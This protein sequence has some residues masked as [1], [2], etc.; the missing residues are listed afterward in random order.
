MAMTSMPIPVQQTIIK[1]DN[2]FRYYMKISWRCGD[3]RYLPLTFL[4]DTGAVG[5]FFFTKDAMATLEA[6]GVLEGTPKLRTVEIDHNS[7]EN[8]HV[9]ECKLTPKSLGD[10]NLIGLKFVQKFGLVLIDE[11]HW[12]F[13]V[14]F[15]CF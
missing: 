13:G 5:D 6:H 15:T 4:V 10:I 14:E 12:R 2:S 11:D 8:P 7:L 1:K 3:G 9:A